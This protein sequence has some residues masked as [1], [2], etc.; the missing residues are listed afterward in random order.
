M[1]RLAANLDLDLVRAFA[2]IAETGSVTR[3]ADALGRQQSTVSLRLQRLEDV[4]GRRLVDRGSRSLRLTPEG[5]AFLGDA[6]RLLGVN[7]EI[8]ARAAEPDMRGRVRL[9]TPEDFATRHL[10]GVLARFAKAHPGVFLEVTCDLTLNLMPRFRRGEFDLALIKREP[11]SARAGQLVW[12]EPLVWVMADAG[13]AA[14]GVLP[15]VVSPRPCIYRR[16]AEQALDRARRPWRVAYTCASLAGSLAAV[17]AGLGVTVL[18]KDMAPLGLAIVDGR[19]LP[20][21]RESE[22]ALLRRAPLPAPAERLADHI[23]RSLG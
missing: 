15:L 14:A 17:K 1:P 5:A 16:R 12:R 11:V 6:R 9:A 22:I 2:L 23:V 19:A 8:V 7:D 20:G 3:A 4:L 18:P 21:L 13:M 10:P